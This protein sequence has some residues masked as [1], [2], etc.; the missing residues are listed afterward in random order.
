MLVVKKMRFFLHYYHPESVLFK[1]KFFSVYAYGLMI[2]FGLIFGFLVVSYLMRKY[3]LKRDDFWSLFFYL[4]IFGLI[5][6]RLGY[7]FFY[8]WPYYSN[9]LEEIIKFWQGGM[10]I[11]GT[12]FLCLL[13][14]FFFSHFKKISFLL[15]ADIFAPALALGQAIGRWGNYFNQEIYGKPT[16]FFLS[17][18][19]DY[20]HRL[21]GYEKFTY[22]HPVFFYSF[23]WLFLLF[24]ILFFWHKKRIKKGKINQGEIFL[25]YLIL[26]SL[27]RFFIEFLRIDPQPVYLSLRMGQWLSIVLLVLAL[28]IYFFLKRKKRLLKK[29]LYN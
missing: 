1:T 14:L 19:I 27:G 23:L 26:H 3:R 12:I 8:H 2:S 4:I 15:L 22:F 16:N 6:A 21:E 9:H 13:V 5:G 10:A 24:L 7:V 25:T 18:P 29:N 17:I 11:H 20:S 28:F